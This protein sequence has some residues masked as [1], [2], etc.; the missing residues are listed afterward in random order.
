MS[1]LLSGRGVVI[2][3]CL[4]FLISSLTIYFNNPAIVTRLCQFYLP[5]AIMSAALFIAFYAFWQQRNRESKNPASG[6]VNSYERDIAHCQSMILNHLPH[7]ILVLNPDGMLLYQ[8]APAEK[9]FELNEATVVDEAVLAEILSISQ[10]DLLEVQTGLANNNSVQFESKRI[11]NEQERFFRYRIELIEGLPNCQIITAT[12]ITETVI[13]LHESESANQAKSQFLANIS[14]EIRT[15]MIG[16]LGSVDLLEQSALN[17]NQQENLNVI[18][19]CSEQ[20]LAIINEILDVSKIEVGLVN[21]NPTC[22]RIRPLLSRSLKIVEPL[23][24]AKGLKVQLNVDEELPEMIYLDQAKMQQ[25]LSNVLSNAV[26]FTHQG[27]VTIEACKSGSPDDPRLA[28]AVKDTGIGISSEELPEIFAPFTQADSSTTRKYG[29]TG[30]GLYTCQKL[31]NLMEGTIRAESQFGIGTIIYIEIPLQEAAGT[32]EPNHGGISPAAQTAD[33]AV[34]NFDPARIL[35][36]E[37]NLLNQK[38]VSQMLHNYGFYCRVV[39]NGLECLNA[40]HQESFDVVLL[41]M[42]MPV[43]DGYETAGIIRQDASLNHV[44][45]IAM[46]ANS[47]VGDREKCLASGCTDYISKP[48]KARELAEIITQHLPQQNRDTA[49]ENDRLL[50][51]E[52]MPELLEMLGEMLESLYASWRKKD[53]PGLQSLGHDIKGT[54]GMYGLAAISQL[55]GKLEK[56]AREHDFQKITSIIGDLEEKY[57]QIRVQFLGQNANSLKV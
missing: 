29:G 5:G 13:T 7:S 47:M 14:H 11:V 2:A 19:E 12:D 31:V 36:T 53:L 30:L 55:A 1:Y 27:S 46:T 41:D 51:N 28:V 10:P 18:R 33:N 43:M 39:S 37:D 50:I 32:A 44:A 38:I 52:L 25:I 26:K 20:L 57:A 6:C 3:V 17:R 40:L 4:I 49:L 22:C 8:N 24:Q 42:Q 35:V 45:V 54:A 9:L 48:F 21:L 15:P 34:L 16:V 23:L 56:A